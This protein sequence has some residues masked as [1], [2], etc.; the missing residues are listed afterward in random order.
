M[1]VP[2]GYCVMINEMRKGGGLVNTN[3]YRQ[4]DCSIPTQRRGRL[5]LKLSAHCG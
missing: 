4:G 2:V 3:M 1:G 5:G